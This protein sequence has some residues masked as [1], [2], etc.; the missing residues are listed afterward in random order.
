MKKFFSFC[1]CL[2]VFVCVV[3][4]RDFDPSWVARTS[5]YIGVKVDDIPYDFSTKDDGYAYINQS[6]AGGLFG[7][8]ARTIVEAIYANQKKVVEYAFWYMD[9]WLGRDEVKELADIEKEFTTKY[10]SPKNENGVYIWSWKKEDG[11]LGIGVKEYEMRLY[12]DSSK[13]SACVFIQK[14]QSGFEERWKYLLTI[15]GVK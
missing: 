7:I 11:F 4:A 5:D 6:K 14:K 8:G 12:R 13:G 9:S 15:I 1:L 2:V 3:S 10:G